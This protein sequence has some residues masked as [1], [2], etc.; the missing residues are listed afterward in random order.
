MRLFVALEI[1]QAVRREVSRRMARL[2]DRLPRARWVD[3]ENLHLTLLFFGQVEEAAVPGLAA[4]LRAAFAKHAPL[5]LRLAGGGTFPPRRPARVA[6]VGMESPSDLVVLQAD[7]AAAAVA[8]IGFT[9]EERP[10]HP[11]VTLA[12]CDPPWPRDAADKVAATFSG[13]VG[14]PFVVDHGVLFESKLSPRGPRY[15]IVESLP[16]ARFANTSLGA[17]APLDLEPAE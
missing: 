12:R 6:W 9:P 2:R 13:G 5:E 14:Q 4:A 16:L 10:F 15:R 8:S 3:A 17:A 7:A 1:P 11:H